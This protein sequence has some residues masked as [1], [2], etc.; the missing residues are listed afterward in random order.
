MKT[1][2]RMT[3]KK[4]ELTGIATGFHDLDRLTNG[5]QRQELV[6]VG[7]GA[8]SGKTS[9]ALGILEAAILPKKGIPINAFVFSLE[10]SPEQIANRLIYSRARV[11]VQAM[12]DGLLSKNGDEP[13]RLA[14][15]GDELAKAPCVIDHTKWLNAEDLQRIAAQHSDERNP[16]GLIFVDGIQ[17]IGPWGNP[18]VTDEQRISDTVRALKSLARCMNVPVIATSG[19][20]RSPIK[21]SRRPKL[22]DLRGS[23]AI[24]DTADVV[25]LLSR[26]DEDPS[27]NRFESDCTDVI[28]AKQRNGPIGELR[29]TYLQDI[30]RFENYTY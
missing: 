15:A 23:G 13:K 11:K 30:C 5:F 16:F 20:S 21:D 18:N 4:G 8:S 27:T 25:L 22:S 19:L 3:L 24:E 26:R 2:E 1:I 6:V 9:L 7:G 14:A 28:V 17:A 10:M 12:R 29:L